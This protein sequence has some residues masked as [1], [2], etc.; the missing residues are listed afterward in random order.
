[1]LINRDTLNALRTPINI[2]VIDV[3]NKTI[4]RIVLSLESKKHTIPNKNDE[5]KPITSNNKLFIGF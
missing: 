3:Q 1:M 2:K 4:G 5:L